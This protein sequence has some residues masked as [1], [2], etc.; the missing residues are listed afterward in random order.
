MPVIRET[1]QFRN[2][3]IGVVR[4]DSGEQQVWQQVGRAADNLTAQVFNVAKDKAQRLGTDLATQI[5]QESLR[6]INPETGRAEAFTPPSNLGTIA[7]DAYEQTMRRR[8]IRSAE[9]EIKNKAQELFILHQY[10]AHGPDKY[11]TDM[12]DYIEK[13]VKVS[14]VNFSEIIQEMGSNYLASTKLNLMAKRAE[15]VRN[16]EGQALYDDAQQFANSVQDFGDDENSLNIAYQMEEMAQQDALTAGIITEREFRENMRNMR[17]AIQSVPIGGLVYGATIMDGED[18]RELT[19]ADMVMLEN[20]YVSRGNPAV[21]DRLPSGLRQIYDKSTESIEEDTD[22]EILQKKVSLLTSNLNT[23]FAGRSSTQKLET[24]TQTIINGAGDNSSKDHREA[25]DAFVKGGAGI[26]DQEVSDKYYRTEDSLTSVDVNYMI[27]SR[28]VIPQGLLNDLSNL[29]DG[30]D[31]AGPEAQV[32]MQHYLRYASYTKKDGVVMNMLTID[33]GLSDDQNAIL[34]TAARVAQVQGSDNLPRLIS[35]VIANR[36]DTEALGVKIK[37]MFTAPRG[38]KS[39]LNSY[40]YDKFDN[41]A[42]MFNRMKPYAEHLIANGL[43]FTELDEMMDT[44]S[45]SI[46]V[47]TK[48][49]VLDV[50]AGTTAGRSMYALD[51]TIPDSQLQGMFMMEVNKALPEGF[52]IGEGGRETDG[53]RVY[54]VPQDLSGTYVS[55]DLGSIGVI[56]HAF[57]QGEDGDLIPVPNADPETGEF[58]FM[59][60]SI[61]GFKEE[62]NRIA[63]QRKLDA[64]IE[65]SATPEAIERRER[66]LNVFEEEGGIE[67]SP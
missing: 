59:S 14:D 38:P 29:A 12:Q 64:I 15:V 28:G 60:F 50:L 6:T 9:T 41:D 3:R 7:Q 52:Y 10:D 58:A 16:V 5:S 57:Y 13:M 61:R 26:T 30:R 19:P 25:A 36:Q 37:N 32:L 63:A 56:Y 31:F 45:N 67:Q 27:G 22:F 8:Y 1:Q 49:I 51:R 35:T 20:A 18:E 48:G 4:A 62:A 40:L 33:G 47:E 66:G 24:T 54:L 23:A 17:R 39:S 44:V 21:V 46:Y 42:A 11:A 53:K 43:G 2:K 34:M 55:D 65:G